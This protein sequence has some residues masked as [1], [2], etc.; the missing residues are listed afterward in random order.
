M[1]IPVSVFI[2]CMTWLGMAAHAQMTP[3]QVQA[4]QQQWVQQQQNQWMQ[5]QQ[6]LGQIEADRRRAQEAAAA[7]GA[8]AEARAREE[9][10]ANDP[11]NFRPMLGALAM[12]NDG[13]AYATYIEPIDLGVKDQFVNSVAP[14]AIELCEQRHPGGG[15]RLVTEFNDGCVWIFWNQRL[16]ESFWKRGEGREAKVRAQEWCELNGDEGQ[17]REVDWQCASG[18]GGNSRL[19]PARFSGVIPSQQEQAARAQ[20]SPPVYAAIGIDRNSKE[21]SMADRR[22][23]PMEAINALLAGNKDRNIWVATRHGNTCPG[24]A[25]SKQTKESGASLGNSNVFITFAPIGVDAH[26]GALR[27]CE[28]VNGKGQCIV[29]TS[30]RN[31]N[32]CS[33]VDLD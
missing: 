7:A 17:C 21:L 10:F 23:T 3:Q 4:Q 18:K 19:R 30:Y 28:A 33:G 25:I 24:I 15:C 27:Q 32:W 26:N 31:K 11:R 1:K 13:T 2:W 6:L 22:R 14:K 29:W 20:R 5:Q 9:A 12:D 8:A 16:L